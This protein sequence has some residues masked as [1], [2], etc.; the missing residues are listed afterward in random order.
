MDCPVFFWFCDHPTVGN[1][2]LSYDG[3]QLTVVA[4]SR[5]VK[6]GKPDIE[7]GEVLLASLGISPGA[8]LENLVAECSIKMTPAPAIKDI[9]DHAMALLVSTP[10][11]VMDQDDWCPISEEDDERLSRWVIEQWDASVN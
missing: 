4:V 1:F 3:E 5:F 6:L 11:E 9:L 8:K 7:K 10:A 2:N